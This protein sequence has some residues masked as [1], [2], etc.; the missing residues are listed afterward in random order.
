MICLLVTQFR[1]FHETSFIF[2]KT[3]VQDEDLHPLVL[4]IGVRKEG[5]FRGQNPP[6]EEW[7]LVI[8]TVHCNK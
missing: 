1:Y 4:I 3:Q 6:L 5:G 7:C 8:Y 2:Q